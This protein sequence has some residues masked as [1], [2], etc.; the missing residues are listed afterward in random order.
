MTSAKPKYQEY[1]PLLSIGALLLWGLWAFMPKL[2]LQSMPPQATLFYA[3]VGDLFVAVPVFF[4]LRCRLQKD[5]KTV[6]ITGIS[7]GLTVASMLAFFYAL[8]HGPVAVVAT[9]TAM[10][11]VIT[12][13][14]ARVV[15]KEKINRMQLI[16]IVMAMV[17]IVLLAG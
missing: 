15:L 14:L 10:Y 12:V 16:A 17:S 7:S 6:R 13:L 5:P 3:A 4:W 11:P 2:A 1:W 8:S 9:L